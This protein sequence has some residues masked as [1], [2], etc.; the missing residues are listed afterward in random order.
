MTLI[1]LL[2]LGALMHAARSFAP[3]TG[4]AGTP[5]GITVGFGY[6]LLSAFLAG[7]L[8]KSLHLPRLTGYLFTG[9]IAGPGMLGLI[10]EQMLVS[11]RIFNGIAIALI[12]LTAGSEME[13]RSMRPQLRSIRWITLV[14]VIGT[15]VLLSLAAYLLRNV[16]PFM[17]PLTATGQVAVAAVLGVTMVAQSPAVAVALRD[18]MEADGPLTRTVLAVV[19]LADIV[20]IV[21]FAIVSSLA[22]GA[23]GGGG[24]VASTARAL[25]RE[26]FGSLL[27]GLPLGVLVGLFLKKVARGGALFVLAVGFVV[28]EVGQRIHLDPLLIALAMGMFIRN[29]TSVGDRLLS[30]IET[31]SLPIYVAFFGVAG[32]TIHLDMLPLVGLPAVLFVLVRGAG[33]LAGS[34]AAARLAKAPEAVQRFAGFGLLPQAGLALALAL[35][36]RRTFPSFGEAASTLV[37]AVVAINELFA[38]IFYRIALVKS[39]ETGRLGR[40]ADASL[41]N[42]RAVETGATQG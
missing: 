41:E 30:A 14:A 2:V 31:G 21:L 17:A 38:P 37:F 19:V 29:A 18:E 11:L 9:L 10:S 32:A 12:A 36:F 7:Q 25:G 23:L 26:I 3:E 27:A 24:E 34:N 8:F 28:A 6:L 42:P 39:G 13:L 5:A 22:H 4:L 33:L 35:M 20:V 40:A 1:L 16:L 15:A